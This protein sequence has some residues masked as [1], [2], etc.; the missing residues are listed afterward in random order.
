[1][2]TEPTLEQLDDYTTAAKYLMQQALTTGD[3]PML[4]AIK[5]LMDETSKRLRMH[6][7]GAALV[8]M[9]ASDAANIERALQDTGKDAAGWW[10]ARFL[11]LCAKS[12]PVHLEALRRAA[13]DHV[14]AWEAWRLAPYKDRGWWEVEEEKPGP[15]PPV[16]PIPL[17]E[18]KT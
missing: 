1:M 4:R 9:P 18:R 16:R 15:P 17:G 10:T 14:A 12:D 13:P 2:T 8:T 7:G 5:A 11:Q 3:G 6:I